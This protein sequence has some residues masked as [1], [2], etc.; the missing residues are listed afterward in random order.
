MYATTTCLP[1]MHYFFFVQENKDE[2]DE[3]QMSMVTRRWCCQCNCSL[4]TSKE[5]TEV[6]DGERD[7]DGT[8][9]PA[10]ANIP[11]SQKETERTLHDVQQII[12]ILWISDKKQRSQHGIWCRLMSHC[13]RKPSVVNYC[14]IAGANSSGVLSQTPVKSFVSFSLVIPISNYLTPAA[15]NTP[16]LQYSLPQMILQKPAEI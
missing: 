5:E 6:E 9:V 12:M 10:T 7:S 13:Q 16:R 3:E 1:I 14:N 4:H 8:D 15:S 11:Y 2:S